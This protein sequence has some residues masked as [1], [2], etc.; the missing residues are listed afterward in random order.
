MLS[1]DCD[2]EYGRLVETHRVARK[3]HICGECGVDIKPGI[4]YWLLVLLKRGEVGQL[5]CC[6][7]CYDLAASMQQ[8]GFCWCWG[9][10]R[11]DH[12]EYINEYGPQKIHIKGD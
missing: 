10:L 9:D 11:N 2:F 8:A 6:D 7:D 12:A 1:C 4:K 5:K 3:T